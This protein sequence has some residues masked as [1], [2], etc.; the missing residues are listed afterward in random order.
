M[1]SKRETGSLC[2]WRW[3]SA[4]GLS[5]GWVRLPGWFLC[6]FGI[7]LPF[8]LYS[9]LTHSLLTHS[10]LSLFLGWGVGFCFGWVNPF[11]ERSEARS[12][13]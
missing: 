9:L 10:L 4:G 3:R 12:G 7:W 11:T 1:R 13:D 8:S 5:L 2:F 6:G